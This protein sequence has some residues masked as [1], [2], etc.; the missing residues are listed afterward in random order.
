[1]SSADQHCIIVGASHAGVQCALRLRRLKFEGRIT[2]VGEEVHA[3]YHRP[4]LSKDYLT[5]ARALDRIALVPEAGYAKNKIDLVRGERAVAVNCDSR[6]LQL[7]GGRS[8]TYDHLV[9]ALGARVRRLDVPGAELAGVHYLRDINDVN[10]IREEATA[11]KRAVVI[12][13]GYIGLETAASLRKLGLEVTIVEAMQRVLQRVT[14]SVVS[15]FYRELHTSEGVQILESQQVQ[16]F[17]GGQRVRAV[18]LESGLQLPADLVVVGIGVIPNT[19]MAATSGL[20]VDNGICVNEFAQTADPNVY[21]IGDCASFVHPLY[22]QRMRIESV[23]NAGEQGLAAA[24]CIVGAPEPYATV[25]W[26]W[27]DQYHVKLQIA[28]LPVDTDSTLVRGDDRNTDGFSVLHL[29]D[30]KLIAI[31]AINRAKDFMQGRKLIAE[32]KQI[33]PEQLKDPTIP[34][35]S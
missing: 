8:L 13:G 29:K 27:S 15:D 21:A 9:L 14:G 33:D 10:A 11:A 31:D 22:D 1:M 2:I 18:Q 23:Q 28:G 34:L 4:P 35:V 30:G 25:P 19:E 3:P 5:G 16:G 17:E 20:A 6:T 26:F 24:R 32:G 7:Q 12:G